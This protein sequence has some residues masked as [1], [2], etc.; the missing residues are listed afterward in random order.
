[1][2]G[3]VLSRRTTVTVNA[4]YSTQ[5]DFERLDNPCKSAYPQDSEGQVGM[6]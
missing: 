5:A 1:M 2:N 6:E 3:I 4:S